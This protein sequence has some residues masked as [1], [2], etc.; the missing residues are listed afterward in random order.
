MMKYIDFHT[1]ILPRMDDGAKDVSMSEQMIAMLS[2]QGA[3]QIVASSHYIPHRENVD[4]FVQ[5]RLEAFERLQQS[6]GWS[7][8]PKIRL[9]A[10]IYL[11]KGLSEQ[12]LKPLFIEGTNALMLELPREPFRDWIL[13]EIENIMYS[14]HAIPIMA[15][16]DRY[17]SWYKKDE[18][19]AVLSISDLV[20]QVNADAFEDKAALKF[21]LALNEMEL[22]ILFGSD[23]HNLG[24]RAPNLNLITDKIKKKPRFGVLNQNVERTLG[25]LG[26]SL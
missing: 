8:F 17:A 23:T 3:E 13:Y 5:R 24:S 12:D 14:L 25:S 11:E 26:M 1:H 15:H 4:R 21:L 19:E 22:P 20:F 6:P 7:S 18:L 9:G 2:A 16:I 10:E